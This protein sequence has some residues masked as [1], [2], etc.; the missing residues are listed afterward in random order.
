MVSGVPKCENCLEKKRKEKKQGLYGT[1]A[2]YCLDPLFPLSADNLYAGRCEELNFCVLQ[3]F[4]LFNFNNF[5]LN[6]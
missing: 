4:C 5:K 1:T 6:V 3:L 2:L